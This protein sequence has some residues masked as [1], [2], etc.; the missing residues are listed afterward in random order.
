MARFWCPR[1]DQGWV[2][3]AKTK[4][5]GE[6]IWVCEECE[7]L[8][9]GSEKPERKPDDTLSTSLAA[10]GLQPLWSEIEVSVDVRRT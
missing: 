1:C 4:R 2:V 6:P 8:W 10:S 7:V 3:S 5:D 9:R